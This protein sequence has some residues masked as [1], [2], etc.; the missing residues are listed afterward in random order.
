MAELRARTPCEGLLPVEIG[1][2]ALT[3]VD[4]GRMTSISPR[5]GAEEALSQALKAAHGVTLPASG[6][7]T[8]RGGARALWFGRGQVL[9]M[10]PEPDAAL[11]RHAALT[12]QSDGWAVVRLEGHLAEDALARL[13]PLDLRQAVFKRNHMARTQ[14]MHMAC[15]IT[16]ISDSAFQIMVFR[17]MAGSAVHDLTGAMRAV[18]ARAALA[19]P[20]S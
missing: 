10:G 15:S 6:R 18:A 16:R 5:R 13:V 17:S 9:L 4:P 2:L 1:A 3:E 7:S 12:D 20:L 19:P 11:S 8:G 14:L